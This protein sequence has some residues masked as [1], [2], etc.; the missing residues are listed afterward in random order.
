LPDQIFISANALS[1]PSAPGYWFL[2]PVDLLFDAPFLVVYLTLYAIFLFLQGKKL[3]LSELNC[4]FSKARTQLPVT[5]KK[6]L[7]HRTI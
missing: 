4:L 1:L 6:S 7:A 2:A 3:V 5:G